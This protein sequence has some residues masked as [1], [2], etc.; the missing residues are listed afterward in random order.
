MINAVHL[1]KSYPNCKI[2][3]NFKTRSKEKIRK[4]QIGFI[5]KLIEIINYSHKEK[6]LAKEGRYRQTKLF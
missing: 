2:K 5:D 3:S 4:G 6:P 1:R